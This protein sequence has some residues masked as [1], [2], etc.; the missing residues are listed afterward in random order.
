MRIIL[1]L[2]IGAF[3]ILSGCLKK[4]ATCSYSDSQV[5]APVAEQEALAD[6]LSAHGLAAT[7]HPAGFYYTI[8]SPGSGGSVANLCTPVTFEYKGQFFNGK[9]FDSSIAGQPV[10][11]ELGRM[12]V[13]WQKGVPLVKNGGVITLYIPPS[14]AY[15]PN[16]VSDA[17]G[18]P[19]LNNDGSYRIPG[20]SYLVFS[21]HVV[22]IQ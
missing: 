15:G 12:I 7:L 16:P 18:R 11:L 10:D 17:Y 8:T 6:S 5:I 1:P 4:E 14:L 9:V 21:V 3:V 2:F 20:N 13:G 19:I 22:S